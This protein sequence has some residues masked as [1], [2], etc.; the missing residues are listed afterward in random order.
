MRRA[1][2]L[3]LQPLGQLL[4]QLHPILLGQL[5]LQPRLLQPQ[6]LP[7]LSLELVPLLALALLLHDLALELPQDQGR[8]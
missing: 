4:P 8:H 1:V 3:L 2:V 5:P 6:L 7:D